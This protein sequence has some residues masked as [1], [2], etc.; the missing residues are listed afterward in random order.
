MYRNPSL[1]RYR[2]C[3]APIGSDWSRIL[4]W[5]CTKTPSLFCSFMLDLRYSTNCVIVSLVSRAMLG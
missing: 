1:S 2:S 4:F 5:I 3:S